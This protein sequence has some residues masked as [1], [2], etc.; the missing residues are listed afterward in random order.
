MV[1]V[2]HGVD[3]LAAQQSQGGLVVQD[4]VVEGV[5]DD[6]GRPHDASP[7]VLL[8]PKLKHTEHQT[9]YAQCQPCQ[10]DIV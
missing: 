4:D 5:G 8:D 1:D 10:A 7:L 9:G 6:L 3:H 2:L